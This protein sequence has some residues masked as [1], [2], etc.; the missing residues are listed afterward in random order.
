MR[1]S[2]FLFWLFWTFVVI[3]VQAVP[4]YPGVVTITQS[5]GTELSVI[6][7]G[8][9]HF[10]YT[11]TEDGYLIATNSDGIFEYAEFDGF[12]SVPT[13]VKAYDA[14][15]RGA[16]DISIISRIPRGD[17]L[18]NMMLPT[19][20]RM[21][22][23]ANTQRVL[24]RYPLKGEPKSLVILVNFSDVEFV[25]PNAASEFYDMLNESGYSKNKATSS[26]RDYF[27]ASSDS[28]FAPNFEVLGPYTL[29]HPCSYYGG[30][31]PRQDANAKEMV[32]DACRAAYN[33]GVDL[34]EYDTDGDGKIDNVFVYYAG[35]N[36]AENAPS[37]TIWPHRSYVQDSP[38]FEYEKDGKRVSVS[39]YDYSCT[40][41][42]RG[43][44]GNEMCGI[45]TFVH[46]F[47]HVL[48]LPDFYITD[49]VSKH[50][51]L[52]RW[53]VMDQG[54]YNNNG[55]TPPT[56]SSYERF[57]LGWL[58]PEVMTPGMYT[59]EPLIESNRAFIVSLTEHNLDG[60]RP[61]PTEFFM[62]E[63]RQR[64]GLDEFGLPGEGLLV[65]HIRYNPMTWD[66]NTVNNDPDDM[67]VSIVRADKMTSDL[68]GDTYP[69]SK[70]VHS[71]Y[72]IMHDGTEI[73]TPLT[74]ILADGKNISFKFAGGGENASNV[75]ILNTLEPFV[76][77]P[78]SVSNVQT[79]EISGRK[80]PSA[81]TLSAKRRDDFFFRLMDSDEEFANELKIYPDETDSSMYAEVEVYMK[82]KMQTYGKEATTI[83][84][85]QCDSD[86]LV[87][88]QEEVAMITYRPTYV[89]PP[90]AHEASGV[91]PYSYIASWDS[92]YDA[93]RY[94]LTC[95]S[96]YDT[97][98]TMVTDFSGFEMSAPIDWYST[99]N[100]V[101]TSHSSSGDAAYFVSTMDT[102]V[103]E[104][105]IIP[106]DSISFWL[107]PNN[108]VNAQFVVEAKGD[109]TGGDWVNIA[110]I[111][112]SSTMVSG[113][114]GYG[115]SDIQ[116]YNQFRF[117]YMPATSPRGGLAFDDF[118]V[119]SS[120][121]LTYTLRREL[122]QDKSYVVSNLKPTTKYFYNVQASDRTENGDGTL[123]YENITDYSNTIEVVT[124]ETGIPEDLKPKHKERWIA[125][126]IRPDNSGYVAYVPE[127]LEN[128]Y[129]Y[130]YTINGSLVASVPVT[131]NEIV[132]PQLTNGQI[133]IIKYSAENDIKRKD[134]YAKFFYNIN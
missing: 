79:L 38:A 23:A 85:V 92:V 8:D 30:D 42:L 106:V 105:Y 55:R 97:P 77:Y 107:S 11:T 100:T 59:L 65:E 134:K 22:A 10:S 5:D 132:I 104:K 95:Y 56:Y 103:S 78:D 66:A 26:A 118:T 40:S 127:V 31:S 122:V 125:V 89:V 20:N 53:D 44:S 19:M 64:I 108:I 120:Q 9:E 35:H 47:G 93:T 7:H 112:I 12:K 16:A 99:F 87:A 113:M 32:V 37:Y 24:T 1:K 70:E 114:K 13:G 15:M 25:I 67:G 49:Y 71:C 17:D 81:V 117:Y 128:H 29:D 57:A 111:D 50:T 90:V 123:L 131:S 129:L 41:E 73:K 21:R 80:L 54:P 119:H 74:S 102:L 14:E 3:R 82:T 43:S 130:I 133:Y 109:S 76:S 4:A 86:N 124:L 83:F 101:S 91:S 110:T 72:F 75:E 27:I 58:T 68:E 34:T 18:R 115:L 94:Y 121:S 116:N 96:I 48:G 28:A 39:V 33:A 88:A 51:T 52:G 6:L 2:F 45:G 62:I 126:S 98:G 36:Q 46:E 61:S 60:S 84:T 63:N 69:G